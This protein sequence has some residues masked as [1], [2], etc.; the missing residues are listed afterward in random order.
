M[1]GFFAIILILINWN[2]SIAQKNLSTD[3]ANVVVRSFNNNELQEFKKDKEFYY[4]GLND[5]SKGLWERFWEWVWWLVREIMRTKNGRTTVWTILI[6]LAIAVILFFVIKVMGMSSGG[7]CARDAGSRLPYT[8]ETEDINRISF[9]DAIKEAVE[10]RNFRLATRLLYLQSLKI[11]SDKGYIQ[12]Q[13]NKSNNDYIR[14]VT[15][16]PW[17]SLFKKLTYSFEYTWYGEMNLAND[18][19]QN[20]QVQFQQF[21]N[22]L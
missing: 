9:D 18:E 17:Q 15:G 11:L 8:T 12:W 21:N 10:N 4:D 16:K 19:F 5:T 2:F 6:G 1:K 13:L 22:Q 3:T 14:E 7:L 20:L